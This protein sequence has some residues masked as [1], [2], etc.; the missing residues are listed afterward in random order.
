MADGMSQERYLIWSYEH[1]GWWGPGRMGY[2]RE[3]SA[4]GRYA[5]A[6]AREIV[7]EAN[8]YAPGQKEVMVA[9]ED[10]DEFA[11]AMELRSAIERLKAQ[12]EEM[13]LKHAREQGVALSTLEAALKEIERLKGLLTRAADALGP[14]ALGFPDGNDIR[15]LIAELRKAAE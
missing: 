15:A 9:E 12:H 13:L 6:E 14:Y 7:M 10:G 5:G 11:E 4:A 1:G 3:L 2:V 8:R